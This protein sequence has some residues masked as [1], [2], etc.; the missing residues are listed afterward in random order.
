MARP[1]IL[2]K[3]LKEKARLYIKECED[4][5]DAF[6]KTQGANSNTFDRLVKVKLPT[7]EGL[8]FYLDV[9]RD[10]LYDW[11]TKD[12]EFSDI[13]N[14]LRERQADLLINKG[15]SGDYNPTIA[16]VLLTKHGYR[17]GSEITGKDGKELKISF[18]SV[19]EK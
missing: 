11:E 1:T 10:T 16:K 13:L 4:T 9:N 5:E 14:T 19:F 2:T 3:E 15:L 6:H 12:E 17:E 7:I 8:A 18:D